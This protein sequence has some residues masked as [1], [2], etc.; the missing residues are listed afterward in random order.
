MNIYSVSKCFEITISG[1]WTWVKTG[2]K[3]TDS[4]SNWAAR[5]PNSVG[6]NEDCIEYYIRLL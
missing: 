6:G 5:E 2:I 3:I 4:Y 1:V